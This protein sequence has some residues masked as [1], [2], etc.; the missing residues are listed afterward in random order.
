MSVNKTGTKRKRGGEDAA[1]GKDRSRSVSHFCSS[2]KF[3]CPQQPLEACRWRMPMTKAESR[4]PSTVTPPPR[5]VLAPFVQSQPAISE[6]FGG[7]RN[8]IRSACL[9]C[10]GS[11]WDRVGAKTATSHPPSSHWLPSSSRF[12][13]S[14][15]PDAPTT[16]GCLDPPVPIHSSKSDRVV[17][18]SAPGA[19]PAR[20]GPD[21]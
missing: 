8:P 3:A 17:A 19:A 14:A 18:L 4:P 16:R 12:L 20:R 21:P 5:H 7:Q 1:F 2:W 6:V 11:Q 13:A 10:A 9:A 15:V